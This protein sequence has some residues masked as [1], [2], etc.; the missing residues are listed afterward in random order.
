[1][2]ESRARR[3]WYSGV[4]A[5]FCA[6]T[7][8]YAMPGLGLPRIDLAILTGNL[9]VPESASATFSWAVGILHA[10][11]FGGV[12]GLAYESG[13]QRF[14]PG[15]GW[16]RGAIWGVVFGAVTGLTVVP[17]LFG[18]GLYGLD[19]DTAMPV[20]WIGFHLLWGIALGITAPER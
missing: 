2:T 11:G 20:S 1:M 4:L 18:G 16:L 7:A 13:V 8:G 6:L 9:L 19:W 15:R 12:L 3:A 5:T 17:I 10:L 14:L